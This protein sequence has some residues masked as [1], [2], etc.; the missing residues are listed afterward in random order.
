MEDGPLMP[1][2]PGFV[3][4]G[5]EADPTPAPAKSAA[6]L[7]P[8]NAVQS[9]KDWLLQQPSPGERHG[10]PGLTDMGPDLG[11]YVRTAGEYLLPGSWPG[12]ISMG[13]AAGVPGAGLL[14]SLGRVGLSSAGGATAEYARGADPG[15]GAL[16]GGGGALAGELLGGAARAIGRKVSSM[17]G[18]ESLANRFG[19]FAGE[20]APPLAGDTGG[21]TLG[22][23]IS[24]EA[25]RALSQRYRE[26][27]SSALARLPADTYIQV[28]ALVE[29]GQKG[30]VKNMPGLFDPNE[31][32]T[33]IDSIRRNLGTVTGDLSRRKMALT[34][35][36]RLDRA[37]EELA[38]ALTQAASGTSVAADLAAVNADYAKGKAL[39]RMLSGGRDNMTKAQSEKFLQAGDFD[40]GQQLE[41]NYLRQRGDLGS[42]LGPEAA[43]S[44]DDLVRRGETLPLA[45]SQPGAYPDARFHLGFIPTVKSL[46]HAPRPIGA[47]NPDAA[48]ET[49]R[50]LGIGAT[51]NSLAP[52]P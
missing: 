47:T 42:K 13:V 16:E 11:Q 25:Q 38:A 15:Q 41:M 23:M 3:P 1:S 28:P 36:T 52:R 20:Q 21:A 12:L 5:F 6:A 51:L 45:I 46:G 9:V 44:L 43:Q 31:A 2:P 7:R 10:I 30:A 18:P 40:R 49:L 8:P 27:V 24:G 17:M 22:R 34:D 39:F 37:E 32:L 29:L 4:E 48:A 33:L 19:Q 26:G 14:P 50:M 35:L